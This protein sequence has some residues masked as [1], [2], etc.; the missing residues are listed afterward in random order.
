MAKSPNNEIKAYG[1]SGNLDGKFTAVLIVGQDDEKISAYNS[2]QLEPLFTQ[3][4]SE[5]N[6]SGKKNT[7][8]KY[9]VTR[10]MSFL[11]IN[12]PAKH[13]T[14]SQFEREISNLILAVQGDCAGTTSS[15]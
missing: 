13:G 1:V 15:R 8:T 14:Q 9:A 2:S 5:P 10:L 11:E 3:M 6:K 12:C 4:H 7:A